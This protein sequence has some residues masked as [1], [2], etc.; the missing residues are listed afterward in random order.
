MQD[1][2]DLRCIT[3]LQTNSKQIIDLLKWNT[4][5]SLFLKSKGMIT[6]L[7]KSLGRQIT[8]SMPYESEA[9]P[10]TIIVTEVELD[11]FIFHMEFNTILQ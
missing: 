11:H 8:L 7:S 6:A 1:L 4:Q 9:C 5:I 2:I 10:N 3:P